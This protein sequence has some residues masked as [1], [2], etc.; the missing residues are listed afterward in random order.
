MNSGLDQVR[1]PAVAGMFYPDH[2]HELGRWVERYLQEGRPTRATNP[3][4]I[5]APHAG[6]VYSGPVAG[7]AFRSWADSGRAVERVI[8]LGPSH[9]VWFQGLAL[10]RAG[11]FRTPLGPVPVDREAVARLAGLPQV[12]FFDAAHA[13]E[14]CLEV[15]LPFLQVL[16][17]RFAMVPLVVGE[18]SDAE[19]AEVLDR[20]WG[21][22]ETRIVVSS[23]LSHYHP[24]AEAVRIDRATAEAIENRRATVLTPQHACGYR[25]IRGLLQARAAHELR[26]ETVDLRNSGD[27]A[28]PRDRVVGYGAFLFQSS[29]SGRG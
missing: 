5:I 2:P 1:P 18:T 7:S 6:Y 16:F 23:D 21:G 24:Y 17:R 25:A 27:T 19:V 9:Y 3:K 14:H 10:P 20:L 12:K 15:E 22:P 28:G 11:E 8:L 13:G 4:A 29:G 26:V